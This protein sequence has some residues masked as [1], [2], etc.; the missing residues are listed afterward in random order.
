MF[1]E[2]DENFDDVAIRTFKVN[3]PAEHGL[4]KSMTGKPVKSVRQLIDRID[5]YKRVEEDQQQ[6]KGKAKVVLQDIRD[7]R[8]DQYNNNRPWRD[9]VGQFAFTAAQVINTIGQGGQA[10][11]GA[12]GNTS[13]RS[14]LGTIS[15]ILATPGRTDSQPSRMMSV[16]QPST[17]DSPP[18]SKK[19]RSKGQ[20]ALSFSEE[21]TIGTLQP[22]DDALVVS[23][24][25]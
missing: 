17:G 24:R 25:I 5:K 4:R 13:T 22:H 20:P 2:I 23:L 9:F 10:G 11:S 19:A 21:H 15:V 3:L 16:A 18:N 6:E 1:N 8:L 12:Q 14:H 7:F